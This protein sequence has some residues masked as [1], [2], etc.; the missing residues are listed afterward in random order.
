MNDGL[1]FALG[2]GGSRGA[3]QVGALRAL[4]EA[5]FTPDLLVG[6][7]IG[8]VNS[9]L[10]GVRGVDLDGVNFL[11]RC[12]M[13]GNDAHLMDAWLPRLAAQTLAAKPDQRAT[14]R[15]VDYFVA[16]GITPDMRFGQIRGVRVALIGADLD[17]GEAVIYGQ[18]PDE[19]VLDGLLAS[20][21]IP[22]WFAPV[23]KNGHVVIDGATVSRVPIEPAMAMGA[24]Q[25]IALPL[26]DPKPPLAE[27]PD[28]YHFVDKLT[29]AYC[30][31]QTQLE[32]A[33]AQAREVPVR[34]VEL[35][36]P[37][38]TNI[39]DFSKPAELIQSGYD[40]A[41]R[42]IERWTEAPAATPPTA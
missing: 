25:I 36:C 34:F 21:A 17:T 24:T 23:M 29:L 28:F 5:G 14:Q 3:L 15:V 6:T 31:R 30:H 4:L 2:S 35:R 26:E 13:E 1:A 32:T 19:R 12:F 9:A 8:A 11:E 20:T 22:P 37:S 42:E 16:K 40:Q 41:R 39:W 38:P 7:S 33:L 27:T 18:D 10:L